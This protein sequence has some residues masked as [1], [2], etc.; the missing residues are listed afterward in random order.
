MVTDSKEYTVTIVVTDDL[1]GGYDVKVSYD[2]LGKDEVPSFSN[3]YTA[4]ASGDNGGNAAHGNNGG[5]GDNAGKGGRGN[6]P[7]TGDA[8]LFVVGGIVAIGALAVAFGASSRRRD[9]A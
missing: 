1:N 9:N 8:T 4:S 7:G 2:G 3:T 5:N 6:L